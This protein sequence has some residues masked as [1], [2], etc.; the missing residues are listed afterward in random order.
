MHSNDAFITE[1]LAIGGDVLIVGIF[2]E[3]P[4]STDAY[5]T[6]PSSPKNMKGK[7]KGNLKALPKLGLRGGVCK[8]YLALD[9]EQFEAR[10]EFGVL[11]PHGPM[12]L[13]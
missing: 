4:P 12:S 5:T 3:A 1:G 9:L 8:L 10:G 2:G 6:Q 7:I 13:E 11:V